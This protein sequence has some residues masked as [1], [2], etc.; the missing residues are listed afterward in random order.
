MKCRYHYPLSTLLKSDEKAYLV[1]VA[2][3][4]KKRS[5]EEIVQETNELFSPDEV[6]RLYGVSFNEYVD[7]IL[8]REN[9]IFGNSEH[10]FVPST[11]DYNFASKSSFE[12]IKR[13]MSSSFRSFPKSDP[14]EWKIVHTEL[15]DGTTDALKE[16]FSRAGLN[17]VDEAV[18]S[19][20]QWDGKLDRF[21]SLAKKQPFVSR[22]YLAGSL[23]RDK[24][25]SKDADVLMA[26]DYCP[27]EKCEIQKSMY[28][29]E[30]DTK[31]TVIGVGFPICPLDLRCFSEKEFKKLEEG[32]RIAKDKKLLF[33][34]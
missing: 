10:A 20:K 28:S 1:C 23:A 31:V 24:E 34:R 4:Q 9:K 6:R 21:V 14:R 7:T 32:Y 27:E 19:R 5:R 17:F 15:K 30:F 26:R 16:L 22:V 25:S 8:D 11:V 2:L 29:R 3:R 12:R 18:L 33:Q 13:E